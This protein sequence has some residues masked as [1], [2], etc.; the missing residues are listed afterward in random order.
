MSIFH[1]FQITSYVS[2]REK[3]VSALFVAV[4][5]YAGDQC[6]TCDAEDAGS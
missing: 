2:R 4:G 6:L 3:V 1:L 5:G